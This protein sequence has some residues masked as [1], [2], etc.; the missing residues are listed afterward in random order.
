M[1]IFILKKTGNNMT[2]SEKNEQENLRLAYEEANEWFRHINNYLWVISS[3]LIAFT[4]FAIKLVICLRVDIQLKEAPI[5]SPLGLLLILV[6]MWVFYCAFLRR[7]LGE[8]YLFHKNANDIEKKLG[9]KELGVDILPQ[10]HE[11]RKKEDDKAGK[12]LVS[13]LARIILSIPS[14]SFGT[15]MA[16]LA[17]IVFIICIV[18]ALWIVGRI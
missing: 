6:L 10:L 1:W 5:M 17:T 12:E 4:V 7:T 13:P 14:G 16:Y 11:I 3:G 9:G 2:D 8:I 15:I 18:L